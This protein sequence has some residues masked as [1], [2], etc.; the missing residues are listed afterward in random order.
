MIL[1][2]KCRELISFSTYFG[3]YLCMN[4]GWK[5]D[6]FNKDRAA[7]TVSGTFTWDKTFADYEREAS[8]VVIEKLK[9]MG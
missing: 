7:A 4:C 2:P 9:E 6:S 3:G 8:E 1:C 5:N